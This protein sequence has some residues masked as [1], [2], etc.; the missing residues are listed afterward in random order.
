MRLKINLQY[1]V[2]ILLLPAAFGAYSKRPSDT[3]DNDDNIVS[4]VV[5]IKTQAL[6]FYWKN[7]EGAKFKSIQHLKQHVEGKG[8][9]LVFATNGGMFNHDFSPKGLYVENKQILTQ[10]DTTDGEGNFYLKP[11]GVFYITTN[12]QA[13]VCPS[14]RYVHGNHIKFATQSGPMLV[15]DGHIHSVFQKGSK[16]LNIRNGVGILPNNQVV[17]ALSKKEINLYDFALFFQ[18]LGCK[19]ALYLDGYVSRMYLPA[20]N[21][22]QADGQFGVIIGVTKAK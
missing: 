7:E 17:F 10:L 4:Y 9:E 14:N 3:K 12:G 16:N 2:M 1:L 5:D 19:N 15:V 22:V 8:L 13:V 21:W 11:N 20:K 6:N 18:Q